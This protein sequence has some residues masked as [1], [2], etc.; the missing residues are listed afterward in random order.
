MPSK[1]QTSTAA[2][3]Q[4]QAVPLLRVHSASPDESGLLEAES[5]RLNFFSTRDRSIVESFRYG[6]LVG[7]TGFVR[8]C[9]CRLRHRGGLWRAYVAPDLSGQDNGVALVYLLLDESLHLL[10]LEQGAESF[11]PASGAAQ[12]LF[13]GTSCKRWG[14]LRGAVKDDDCDLGEHYLLRRGRHL[15]EDVRAPAPT[16]ASREQGKD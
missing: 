3:A 14:T 11:N 16:F 8:A 10:G 12:Q 6:A 13:V 7:T 1:D 4:L 9:A 5:E 15:G 2:P